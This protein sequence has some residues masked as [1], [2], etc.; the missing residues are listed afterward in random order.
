MTL[1]TS[2]CI[3]SLPWL[4]VTPSS[5]RG[6]R[7]LGSL[8]LCVPTCILLLILL[9][10]GGLA[11]S[12][13]DTPFSWRLHRDSCQLFVTRWSSGTYKSMQLH[14]TH[15]FSALPERGGA[16]CCSQERDRS[17]LLLVSLPPRC[18][19]FFSCSDWLVSVLCPLLSI[20]T[21]SSI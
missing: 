1:P 19:C 15:L 16:T 14:S 13:L 10:K 7:A 20:L 12:F 3:I 17:Q 8:L 18:L 11:W 5:L 21:V 4:T 9:G 6:L 2:L